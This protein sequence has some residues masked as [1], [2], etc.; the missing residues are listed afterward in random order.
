M[1]A[2]A[3]TGI[4]TSVTIAHGV[5]FP[6]PFSFPF[7]FPIPITFR[8]RAS[9]TAR[10]FLRAAATFLFCEIAFVFVFVVPIAIVTVVLIR[11]GLGA[12]ASVFVAFLIVIVVIAGAIDVILGYGRC[13]I[14]AQNKT[15]IANDALKAFPF[16][17]NLVSILCCIY[18][19]FLVF[20]YFPR[21]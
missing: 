3:T 2:E 8:F 4:V 7:P 12:T 11:W 17:F 16:L 1:I 10:R 20:C 9:T 18:I 6:F 5:L 21:A 19:F 14:K 15:R 13:T